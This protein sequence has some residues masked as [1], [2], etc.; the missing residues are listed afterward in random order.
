MRVYQNQG[1]FGRLAVG[2]RQVP[3]VGSGGLSV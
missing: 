2:L 1:I 3:Y